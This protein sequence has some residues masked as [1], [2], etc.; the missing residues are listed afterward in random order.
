MFKRVLPSY[1][2]ERYFL[3][4]EIEEHGTILTLDADDAQ[5]PS[6]SRICFVYCLWKYADGIENLVPKLSSLYC[7]CSDLSPVLVIETYM[8]PISEDREESMTSVVEGI[9]KAFPQ[10][11]ESIVIFAIADNMNATPGL[12][13]IYDTCS[14]LILTS[15]SDVTV[16]A[17]NPDVFLGYDQSLDPDAFS[18]VSQIQLSTVDAPIQTMAEMKGMQLRPPPKSLV[19]AEAQAVYNVTIA[20]IVIL[21][22]IASYYLKL[23]RY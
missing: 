16:I 21:G 6:D 17:E 7:K 1:T 10:W 9:R 23:V 12:E 11:R 19:K 4:S 13:F 14:E 5:V 20:L 18:G 3:L 8:S 22:V 2:S 15:S